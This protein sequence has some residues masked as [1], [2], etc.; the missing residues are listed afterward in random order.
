[1]ELKVENLLNL[2]SF[3]ERSENQVLG[4]AF[5]KRLAGLRAEPFS[6]AALGMRKQDLHISY[7][8]D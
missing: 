7:V 4:Q 3:N 8:L 1:M 2:F 5:F 6:F